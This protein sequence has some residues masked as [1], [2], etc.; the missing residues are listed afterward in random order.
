MKLRLSG[1]TAFY[2][3]M[4]GFVSIKFAF[5][6]FSPAAVDEVSTIICE[7]EDKKANK[8]NDINTHF[9]KRAIIILAPYLSI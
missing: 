5:Y 2:V 3:D 6:V 4:Y 1:R 7:L 8:N 9:L